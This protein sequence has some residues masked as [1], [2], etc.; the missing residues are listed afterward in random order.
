M[1]VMFCH[2]CYMQ[3]V[4]SKSQ[5]LPS[6][7]KRVRGHEQWGVR[8]LWSLPPKV[9]TTCW[10]LWGYL[11]PCLSRC[12]KQL[13]SSW[14]LPVS[15]GTYWRVEEKT[16]LLGPS[17]L[18]SHWCS[19]HIREN[20]RYEGRSGENWGSSH[21]A[22]VVVVVVGRQKLL[23]NDRH[24]RSDFPYV[25][26]KEGGWRELGEEGEDRGSTG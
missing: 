3:L 25:L 7:K 1:K 26:G 16:N 14:D 9:S 17:K 18:L 19:L 10:N 4:R 22:E 21:A 20:W 13:F 11:G 23:L 2:L 8:D 12:I 15:L 5:F 6:L 24:P